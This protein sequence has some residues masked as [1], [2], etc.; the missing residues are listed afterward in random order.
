MPQ[1]Q[2]VVQVDA[3][4]VQGDGAWVR[5][6]RMSYGQKQTATRLLAEACGGRV[7]RSR[8]EAESQVALT[9]EYLTE[10][11]AFT[12]QLLVESVMAWNWVDDAGQPLPL[13][14]A[15]PA[16]VLRLTDDEVTFL[17][18]AIRGEDAE[19]EKN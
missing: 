10:Q 13:P 6:R 3:S 18:T 12:Q 2:G 9:T 19:A 8:A 7:P 5:V 17:A 14:S 11:D 15:E 1:R 16:V 4:P